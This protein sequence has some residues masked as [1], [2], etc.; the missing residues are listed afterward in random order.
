MSGSTE[1]N[2]CHKTVF[3]CPL[4]LG[5]RVCGKTAGHLLPDS[6]EEIISIAARLIGAAQFRQIVIGI[7]SDPILDAD[8]PAQGVKIARRITLWRQAAQLIFLLDGIAK[9]RTTKQTR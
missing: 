3:S 4:R 9:P 6:I 1:D 8:P 2:L 5:C 7:A